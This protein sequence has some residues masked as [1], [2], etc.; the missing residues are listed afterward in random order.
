[1]SKLPVLLFVVPL[2]N[3]PADWFEQFQPFYA[4][5]CAQASG[6]EHHVVFVD[7]GS[8]PAAQPPPSSAA[9]SFE[10]VQYSPNRGK[11]Y[12]VRAGEAAASP[13][14]L[15][16]T[17]VDFPYEPASAARIVQALEAGT[18]VAPGIRN[19]SYFAHIS[20]FRRR[21]SLLHSWL[22]KRL[23]RLPISDT[24]CGLKGFSQNGRELLQATTIDRFLFDLELISLAFGESNA[25]RVE[26]VEVNLRKS[27]QVSSV[28][29]RV[30][31]RELGN[32]LRLAWRVHVGRRMK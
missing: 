29:L 17:D 7:D 11:G 6:Y 20:G 25:Y 28:S 1:M 2:Y 19:T 15:L 13:G 18:D 9:L 4:A 27:V 5:F 16:F 32:F 14:L 26:A 31:W 8:E 23:F 21:L 12:A 10:W 3:P 22:I 30:L 24:Q